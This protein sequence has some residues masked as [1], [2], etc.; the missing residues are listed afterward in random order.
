MDA[1]AH[2]V[3]SASAS[4]G[5]VDSYRALKEEEKNV[6]KDNKIAGLV[7]FSSGS[8]PNNDSGSE[9]YTRPSPRD[10]ANTKYSK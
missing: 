1:E 8:G 9:A 6:S 5:E 4:L 10:R 7:V 2:I 3:A